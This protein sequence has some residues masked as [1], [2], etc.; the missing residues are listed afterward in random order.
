MSITKLEPS[1][2]FNAC[3]PKRFKFKT[4]AEL[5]EL[6]EVVG[7]E[8]AVEAIRFG[9][10]IKRNGYNLYALGPERSGKRSVVSRF[11]EQQAQKEQAPQDWCYV[12]NFDDPQ[13]PNAISLPPGRAVQFEKDMKEQVAEL[14]RVVPNA[15]E[16]DEYRERHKEIE[17]SFTKKQEQAFEELHREANAHG[18]AML[19]TP[20]GFIFAPINEKGETIEP[21]EFSKLSKRELD[22]IEETVAVLQERLEKLGQQIP[23]WRREVQQEIKQLDREVVMSVVGQLLDEL[24]HSYGDLP[25]VLEYIDAVQQ[26]VI[27]HAEN[28]RGDGE[29]GKGIFAQI[30]PGIEAGQSFLTRYRVNVIVDNSKTLGAPVT[31]VDHP[32]FPNLVGRVEHQVQMGALVTDFTM[33]K[34]GALHKTNGG[35]LLLDAA[36]VLTQPYAWEGL[37]R[38]LKSGEIRIESLGQALSLISTASLEPEAIPLDIKFVLLGDRLLYYLLSEYDP[39]FGE[40]FKV[41]A[42]FDNAIERSPQN[43]DNF[44]LFIASLTKKEN[45]RPL[46]ADAVA[47]VIEEASRQVEDTTKLSARFGK[48]ADFLREADYWADQSGNKVIDREEVNR[49]IQSHEHRLSRL[50]E[51][52]IE[53]TLRNTLMIATE[54]EKISQI[55]GLSVTELGDHVFGH[56]NRITATVHVG[57]GELVDIEREIEM[58]GPIHSKGVL[59]L[60]G[61]ISGRYCKESPLSLSASLVFEQTY[62]G[63]EGDSASSAELLVLL[64]ALAGVP[65]K[66]SLAVT[67]SVNQHGQI[68]AVGGVNEKIEGFFVVCKER[69]LTGEQGVIVP[70]VNVEHLMLRDDVVKAVSDG[71][72]HI[73]TV[74]TVDDGIEI[75][76]GISAGERDS[77]G[78]FPEGSI[79]QLVETRLQLM[80]EQAH[81]HGKE[82][83]SSK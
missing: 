78:N 59:I 66:Q 70:R 44:A 79:N 20:T 22:K 57:K 12:F 74:D 80:A 68:Q 23:K 58:G 25:E 18:M 49:A 36:K 15:L 10:G 83:E 28:F 3:D 5:P 38:V 24:H 6:E 54:G 39:E 14:G 40:L 4:T 21:K 31:F 50:K 16:T 69:G 60:S 52:M 29:D 67:G 19:R 2:L 8:R 77:E 65:I 64:S 27:E 13:K 26:D 35:Y 33:I 45:L 34:P 75:L 9:I 32:T 63:V 56:P 62:G 46:S 76:T 48:I 72:F 82:E 7:Q 11:I 1:A 17:D 81:E 42:D 30:F 47:R 55:N 73:Y 41:A 61:Y 51:R 43:I 53:A 71:E 37:K